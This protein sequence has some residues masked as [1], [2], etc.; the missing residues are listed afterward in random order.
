MAPGGTETILLVEDE[1]EVRKVVCRMLE[2]AGY[3]IL[4]A[5]D[6]KEALRLSRDYQDPIHLL[7]TDVVMP[8]MSGR[9]LANRILA[10]R[11]QAKILFT[12]GYTENAILHHGVL[13]QGIS[14]INKPFKY[15][16]LVKKVREV[17]DA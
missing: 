8:G 16:I 1:E 15:N 5:A 7:F 6:P 9:E 4:A 14:F 2:K 12:S 10:Q 13:D 3:R 17:L 11:P